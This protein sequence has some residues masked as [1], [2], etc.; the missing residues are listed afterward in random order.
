MSNMDNRVVTVRTFSH[1]PPVNRCVVTPVITV[2]PWWGADLAPDTNSQTRISFFQGGTN[3]INLIAMHNIINFELNGQ[4]TR[5]N[6][7]TTPLT[8]YNKGVIKIG[9]S[10]MKQSKRTSQ[11][12]TSTHVRLSGPLKWIF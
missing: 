7:R 2:S 11:G 1:F 10:L 8:Q 3:E 9:P 12:S 4:K 5:K 6:R